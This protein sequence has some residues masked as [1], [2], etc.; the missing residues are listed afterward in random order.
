MQLTINGQKKEIKAGTVAQL[1]ADLGVDAAQVAV[2]RNLEIVPKSRYG[3]TALAERD[4]IEI[5]EFIGGG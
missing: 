3:Q 5:V 1:L 4:S 2:E